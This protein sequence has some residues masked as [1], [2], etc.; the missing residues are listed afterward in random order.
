MYL[1]GDGREALNRDLI[2]L[3]SKLDCLK[4]KYLKTYEIYIEKKKRYELLDRKWAERD[5][6]LKVIK[7]EQKPKTQK[8]MTQ[9]EILRLIGDLEDMCK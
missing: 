9:E 5:G 3:K 2:E 6:R 7:S 1:L 4:M 8:Q